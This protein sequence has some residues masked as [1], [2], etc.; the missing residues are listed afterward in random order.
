MLSSLAATMEEATLDLRN[1]IYLALS[2]NGDGDDDAHHGHGG[3][4]M[5][6]G[7]NHDAHQQA[8]ASSALATVTNATAD[9][10]GCGSHSNNGGGG[11]SESSSTYYT[12]SLSGSLP[13]DSLLLAMTSR[14]EKK[15]RKKKHNFISTHHEKEQEEEQR[16]MNGMGDDIIGGGMDNHRKEQWQMK[17]LQV[18]TIVENAVSNYELAVFNHQQHH[19]QFHN[20]DSITQQQHC[21]NNNH[22]ESFSTL[23]DEI[24]FGE[25]IVHLLVALVTSVPRQLLEI[26]RYDPYDHDDEEEEE[27]YLS[28]MEQLCFKSAC[29]ASDILRRY[30]LRGG[31]LN[32]MM[33]NHPILDDEHVNLLLEEV[34]QICSEPN[35]NNKNNHAITLD[36][37]IALLNSILEERHVDRLIYEREQEANEVEVGYQSLLSC[38]SSKETLRLVHALTHRFLSDIHDDG[39]SG[40]DGGP[41]EASTQNG[42]FIGRLLEYFTHIARE[43]VVVE[44]HDDDEDAIGLFDAWADSLDEFMTPRLRHDEAKEVYTLIV[45]YHV[46]VIQSSIQVM[47]NAEF[48]IGRIIAE[49]EKNNGEIVDGAVESMLMGLQDTL[50][51]LTMTVHTTEAMETLGF[52]PDP[53][54]HVIFHPL[55]SSYARF[56]VT[57]WHDSFRFFQRAWEGGNSHRDIENVSIQVDDVLVRLCRSTF[58]KGTILSCL[59]N[60]GDENEIIAVSLLRAMNSHGVNGKARFLLDVAADRAMFTH[61]VVG[62]TTRIGGDP[63]SKRR[64][65]DYDPRLSSESLAPSNTLDGVYPSSNERRGEMTNLI[66]ACLSLMRSSKDDP[67]LRCIASALMFNREGK[68]NANTKSIMLDPLNPWHTISGQIAKKYDA[69]H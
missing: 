36:P 19:H 54:I 65:H 23:K 1:A 2:I 57:C 9:E 10:E 52:D 41:A 43:E 59:P 45:R 15:K 3:G 5:M 55:V 29:I 68:D 39:Y 50:R 37:I 32:H 27:V 33:E 11:Y 7:N 53:E 13:S 63:Q 21:E 35:N 40:D 20:D 46:V 60:A 64:R 56:T 38:L 47:E 12:S 8:I 25:E 34:V 62:E 48:V 24:S 66:L 22:N 28:S 58:G 26:S 67:Q 42:Y 30:Y 14:R 69:S 31:T 6:V 16:L 61:N 18:A 44:D 51:H 17:R 4:I 49:S